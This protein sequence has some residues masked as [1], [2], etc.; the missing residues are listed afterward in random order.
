MGMSWEEVLGGG[1]HAHKMQ[2][3][4]E[5]ILSCLIVLVYGRV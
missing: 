1:K 5:M 3:F 4:G 2:E